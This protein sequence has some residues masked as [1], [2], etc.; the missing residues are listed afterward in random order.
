MRAALIKNIGTNNCLHIGERE[1]PT[2]KENEV[3]VKVIAAGVNYPD[4]MQR[5][6][7]YPPP[8]GASDLLG[9]E[10]SGTIEKIGN[11]VKQ[12]KTGNE[13]CALTNGGGYG[14]YVCVCADHCLPIPDNVNIVDAAGLPETYFTV[15]SNVFFQQNIKKDSILLIH[16]GAGGIGTTAIQLGKNFGLK[17]I[18]TCSS[19]EKCNFCQTLGADK[20][21]DYTKQD[22]VD[23]VKNFGGADIIINII[24][25][26]YIHRNLQCANL[27][28]KI[29][30][31][32][33]NGGAK[34]TA[35]F[36]P[37]MLKRIV[38]TGSTLRP[39]PIEFKTA[40]TQD[41]QTKVWPL[42]GENKLKTL[43]HKTYPLEQAQQAHEFIEAKKHLG[44]ILLTM[45]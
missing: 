34:I 8:K 17:T 24:G 4:I 10:I 27:D 14:E 38:F 45:N 26:D 5:K 36:M 20:A 16:G 3:L 19:Q 13:I 40:I 30:Q 41:L 44:K 25:G 23:I 18:A 12:W 9:L 32:A 39:R 33:F 21:I 1:K 15:W 6:G 28:C 2:P 7:L 35:D 42:F 11:G 31:L 43:T 29:I 37:L 22:F